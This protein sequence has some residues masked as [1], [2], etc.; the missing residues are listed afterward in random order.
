MPQRRLAAI[1]F[2]DIV[3]YTALM[4]S[5]EDHALEILRKNREIHVELIKQYNGTLIKE[6][7]DGTLVQFNSA[8]DAVQCAIGI[9]TRAREEVDGKI[10]IGI[11]LGEVTFENNDVFGDG[12]NIASRLQSIADPGGIY[13]SES[14]QKSIRAKSDIQTR[15]LGEVVLKN[16][17]Y[18]VKIYA[19]RGE[20]LPVVAYAKIKR[21][22]RGSKKRILRSVEAII[23]ISVLLITSILWIRNRFFSNSPKISSL[24]F[25]PFENFTGN[26]T[27]DYLMAGM[28]DALIGEVGKIGSLRVPGTKTANAY[29]EINKSIPKIASE[30]KVDAGVETSVSCFGEDSIC[31]QVKV[32]H[33]FPKEKQVWVKDYHVAK[34]RIQNWYKGLAKE[35]SHEINV[36]LTQQEETYLSTTDTL[37]PLAY[38]LYMKGQFY[39]DQVNDASLK[40][41]IEYY[42]LAI[43]IEPDWA[44]PYAGLA[45]VGAY[46]QQMGFVSP[47]I[48]YPMIKA[49]LDRALKLDPNTAHSHYVNAVIAVWTQFDWKKGEIEFLKALEINP[50][51]VRA[52]IFYAHLLTILRR[53]KEALEQ[54]SI[55]KQLDP[56]NPLTQGL[57]AVV[58]FEAGDCNAAK[59]AAEKGLTIEPDHYFT[60]MS[61]IDASVCL[62]D[63]DKAFEMWKQTNLPLWEKYGVVEFLKKV[64]REKGWKAVMQ[65]AVRLNE[66]LYIKDGSIDYYSQASRYIAI[67]NYDK[68]L[69]CFELL[70]E[71]KDPNLPYMSTNSIYQVLKNNSRYLTYLEKMNLPVD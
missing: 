32:V 68:A 8:V 38:D 69:D 58:L 30:L 47:S 26:D 27:L 36:T 5:N 24:V 16:V 55:A 7:G 21:L 57:Y 48:A 28:H 46:Q 1:M 22:T 6:M 10:R 63:F 17:D 52:H 42:N 3:G 59:N 15:C 67:E 29:K 65:E 54:G 20:G 60:R 18:P 31:F 71:L 51:H 56:L 39:L 33:A 35:I 53:T 14:L 2:T 19:V 34:S 44:Q 4:G 61:L 40:K 11:H 41:A 9:Q 64:Y 13:I 50:N 12:V 23:I 37:D 70:I 45:E 66:E 62:G 49:N 25:L 43:E